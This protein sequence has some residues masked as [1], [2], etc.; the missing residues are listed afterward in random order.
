MIGTSTSERV[1]TGVSAAVCL[2]PFAMFLYAL[3]PSTALT[4]LLPH[5][6][7]AGVVSPAL[8]LPGVRPSRGWLAVFC[9]SWPA[10]LFVVLARV[11]N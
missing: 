2:V 3:V 4:D 1:R 5:L 10:A 9:W 8:L 7:V 6:R 11:Y